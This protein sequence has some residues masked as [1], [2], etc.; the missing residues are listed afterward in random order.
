M[1]FMDVQMPVMDGREATRI[2]RQSTD[3]YIR[4]IPIVAM[5]ADA[6]A[7]DIRSCRDSGMDGHIAKPIEIK[8]LQAYL[9]KFRKGE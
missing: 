3:E 2:I 9:Q 7:E 8:K 5:T 1:I 4:S 6:F